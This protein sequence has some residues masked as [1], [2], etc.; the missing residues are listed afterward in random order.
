MEWVDVIYPLAFISAGA[1]LCALGIDLFFGEPPLQVH[2]VV[3]M[4]KYLEIIGLKVSRVVSLKPTPAVEFYLGIVGWFAGA[5]LVCVVAIGLTIVFSWLPILLHLVLL[6]AVLK[7]LLSWRML[8]DEVIAVEQALSDSIDAGR[9][10]VS[11]LVSRDVTNLDESEIRQAAISTLAE[12]L[13]DSV[14]APLFWFAVAGLPGAA[15]YRFANTADAMWGY[16]GERRGRDWTW[17]GKW[18]AR[19]DDVLSW[20][21]ARITALLIMVSVG[22]YRWHRLA[23]NACLTPSPNSG[24][25]MGAM[26]LVQNIQLGKAGVYLLNPQGRLP[27]SADTALA[28]NK[29]NNVIV[30]LMLIGACIGLWSSSHL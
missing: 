28:L 29:S 8:R 5:A 3:W 17:A 11:W 25:P 10:R 7:T 13:N 30:L 27:D 4:G 22:D 9:L 15:V 21:P 20:V 18:A 23:A 12:N 2:P 6:G 16:I 24:W 26:A 19:A 14:V 1:M